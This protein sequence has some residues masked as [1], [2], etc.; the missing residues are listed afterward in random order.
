M[1]TT[2]ATLQVMQIL[3]D[4]ATRLRIDSIRATTAAVSGHPA[5]CPWAAENVSVPFVSV[6][7]CDPKQPQSP[8]NDVFGASQS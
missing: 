4:K 2:T 3:Q 8:S 1:R 7:R 6:M 5:S